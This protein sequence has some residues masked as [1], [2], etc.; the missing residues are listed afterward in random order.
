M[1]LSP[2][3]FVLAA[4]LLQSILNKAFQQGNLQL[5]INCP[6]CPDFPIIQYADDSLV[7]MQ[8]DARQWHTMLIILTKFL[9]LSNYVVPS[10]GRMS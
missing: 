1:I 7:V 10:G 5:P 8:A 2:L 6:S 3:L 4:D 9:M